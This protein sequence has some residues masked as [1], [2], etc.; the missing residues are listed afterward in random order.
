M[1]EQ[2]LRQLRV[3]A[4]HAGLPQAHPPSEIVLQVLLRYPVQD[5]RRR[6]KSET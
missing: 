5:S 1:F 4:M 6:D 3:L 2:P